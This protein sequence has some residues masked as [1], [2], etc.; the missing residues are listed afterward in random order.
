MRNFNS[1]SPYRISLAISIAIVFHTML[2][3]ALFQFLPNLDVE[4]TIPIQLTLSSK[5]TSSAIQTR[6]NTASNTPEETAEEI[7]NKEKS[8]NAA[9]EIITTTGT[10]TARDVSSK[11]KNQGIDDKTT[12]NQSS[13]SVKQ[14][15]IFIPKVKTDLPDVRRDIAI[16]SKSQAAS[17]SFTEI[18]SLFQ[19]QE[20][21][22]DIVQISSDPKRT[23][24][25]PYEEQLR[26]KL[27]HSK[28]QD[29]L[30]PI[31]SKLN[32]S[33]LVTLELVIF[34]NGTIRNVLVKETSDHPAL[35]KA[36][37]KIALDASPY[38]V[39]PASD[40][41]IGFR[42]SVSIRYKPISSH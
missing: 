3:I 38:P 31:I 25:S 11:H 2:G 41:S 33:R 18:S 29:Q 28:Y 36:V 42:Y 20:V 37:R 15:N 34:P 24:I 32:Q 10:S 16:S 17:K 35:D 27:T 12:P 8:L 30:Y 39:P 5:A 40:K 7:L 14:E 1:S 23:Q 13:K 4:K 9:K 21:E 19:Q 22:T 6:A 26:K